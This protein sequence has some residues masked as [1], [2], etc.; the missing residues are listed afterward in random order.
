M[1][2]SRPRFRRI[3]VAGKVPP[4]DRILPKGL[5]YQTRELIG[6]EGTKTWTGGCH[7]G[8]VRYEVESNLEDLV[9]CNCSICQKR[10]WIL[11]FAPESQFRL[12]TGSDELTDYQFNKKAIHHLFCETCGVASFSSGETP[13]GGRMVAIN[14]RCLDGIDLANLKPRTF[15]GRSL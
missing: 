8:R 6:M 5:G 2:A 15:D 11:A 3:E 13:D 1:E 7:C 12:L 10:G 4:G 9:S 14:V